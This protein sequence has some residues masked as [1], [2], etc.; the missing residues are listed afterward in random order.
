MNVLKRPE[1]Y[2]KFNTFRKNL[3]VLEIQPMTIL[4]SARQ[5]YALNLRKNVDKM[6]LNINKEKINNIIKDKNKQT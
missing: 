4:L 3:E 2:S 1:F 5:T 6:G